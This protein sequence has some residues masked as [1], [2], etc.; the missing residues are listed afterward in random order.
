MFFPE[1]TASEDM[2][3]PHSND[4]STYQR[5]S[6]PRTRRKPPAWLIAYQRQ[7]LPMSWSPK[8]YAEKAEL[9][10]KAYKANDIP[11]IKAVGAWIR[12][13]VFHGEHQ[14]NML[15]GDPLRFLMSSSNVSPVELSVALWELARIGGDDQYQLAWLDGLIRYVK[16][17]RFPRSTAEAREFARM[18]KWRAE[19]LLVA[20]KTKVALDHLRADQ[21]FL[22][23]CERFDEASDLDGLLLRVESEAKGLRVVQKVLRARPRHRRNVFERSGHF[24]TV[25]YEGK[26][27]PPIPHLSGMEVAKIL[28]QTPGTRIPSLDLYKKVLRLEN[29]KQSKADS[30]VSADQLAQ[31]KLS[32]SFHLGA[33]DIMTPEAR[34]KCKE[35]LKELREELAEAQR[36]NDPARKE[37]LRQDI[38]SIAEQLAQAFTP[39]GNPRR[40]GDT[41]EKARKA[42]HGAIERVKDQIEK[43]H[44]KL[45]AHL[46]AYLITGRSCIYNPPK[47]PPWNK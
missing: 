38:S 45:G 15:L 32:V 11:T 44:P 6:L 29:N 10:V 34:D 42:V 23:D 37:K 3:V 19:K 2:G 28:L 33:D 35:R 12:D 26:K 13:S 14:P 47:P 9:L 39:V 36:H 25:Q 30:A 17:G 20:G 24:W 27:A 7:E 41:N 1:T 21:R 46:R 43:Y 18:A 40:L 22:R 5:G 8:E 16:A 4:K 31:Q